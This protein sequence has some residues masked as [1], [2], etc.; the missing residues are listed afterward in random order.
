MK[1]S[2]TIAMEYIKANATFGLRDFP[3]D[4]YNIHSRA[5]GATQKNGL[6]QEL[7]C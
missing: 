6:V 3:F 5:E 4:Q 1:E 2:S 7:P